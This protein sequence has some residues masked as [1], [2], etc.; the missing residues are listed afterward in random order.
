M[1]IDLPEKATLS[2]LDRRHQCKVRKDFIKKE[3]LGFEVF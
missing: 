2:I 1:A 3:T